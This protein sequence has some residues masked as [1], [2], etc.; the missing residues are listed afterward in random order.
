[1]ERRPLTLLPPPM[2][3]RPLI[4]PATPPPVRTRR[5]LTPLQPMQRHPL[6]GISAPPIELWPDRVYGFHPTLPPDSQGYVICVKKDT[7]GYYEVSP[8][9][10]P[11]ARN[12]D[13]GIDQTLAEAII[14]AAIAPG[15][16]VYV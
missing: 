5:P 15:G 12:R 7:Q 13:M 14:H 1:M 16:R 11:L 2:P 9:I 10:D 6:A 4:L 3:R 8:E